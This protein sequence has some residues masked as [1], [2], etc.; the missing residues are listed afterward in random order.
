MVKRGMIPNREKKMKVIGITGGTGAGKSTVCAELKKRGAE[1]IDADAISRQVS[2]KGGIAF[3]EIVEGFGTEILNDLGEIDRRALGKI[4]F[5][6]TEKLSLLNG[7]THKHI[8]AEMERRMK[9][10]TAKIAVLDV[11][12]LFDKDFPLHCDLTVAIIAEPE[13]R[14]KRIM[15]RDGIT[16]DAA[17]ARMKNQI[18][19]E[20]YARLAD[21]CVANNGGAEN[22]ALLA[23]K[24]IKEAEK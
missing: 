3:D 18:S 8:F 24:I 4:V 1:I 19:D 6:D 23:E 5:N 12:L 2:Q 7:I 9:L 16:Y 11:P 14:L 22:T 17:V 15:A 20:D 13:I 10:C 21:I